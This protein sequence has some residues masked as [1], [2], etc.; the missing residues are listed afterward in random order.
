MAPGMSFAPSEPFITA[1]I[2]GSREDTILCVPFFLIEKREN[3]M[4]KVAFKQGMKFVSALS[5]GGGCFRVSKRAFLWNR[6]P[7]ESVEWLSV[8]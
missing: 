3:E 7:T 1:K 2:F 6:Y 8:E 4:F 5:F